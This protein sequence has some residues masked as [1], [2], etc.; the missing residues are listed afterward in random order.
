[1]TWSRTFPEHFVLSDGR[2]VETLY[3]VGQLVLA[4]PE[5]HRTNGHWQDAIE[6]LMAAAE[7]P[8]KERLATIVRIAHPNGL[9]L[10]ERPNRF[11]QAF[12]PRTP[13]RR[14]RYIAP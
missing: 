2:T 11:S 12:I 4:L 6:R 10:T 9:E 3:E 7:D 1:M 5:R 8:S 14:R 13:L